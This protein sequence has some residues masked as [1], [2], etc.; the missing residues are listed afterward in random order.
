MKIEIRQGKHPGEWRMRPVTDAWTQVSREIY[1]GTEQEAGSIFGAVL[2][3][4]NPAAS[5]PDQVLAALNDAVTTIQDRLD[6]DLP[7]M[8][9]LHEE[10]TA[11]DVKAALVDL[12]SLSAWFLASA[13]ESC[14][15]GNGARAVRAFGRAAYWHGTFQAH[16][17]CLR[18]DLESPPA[19]PGASIS[20]SIKAADLTVER[21]A[22]KEFAAK[23]G[24]ARALKFGRATEKDA[25]RAAWAS[26]KYS[27]RAL[28]AEQEAAALGI[29]FDTARK[30]LRNTPDPS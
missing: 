11:A 17:S 22:M 13:F 4:I 21:Q 6:A 2:T 8:P 30:A 18:C 28:C 29:S 20:L 1:E 16:V 23:G 24:K 9:E 15:Q 25:I 19:D 12:L 26:G 3:C 10:P 7:L 14:E 5:R 27:T